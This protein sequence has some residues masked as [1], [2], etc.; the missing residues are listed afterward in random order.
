MCGICGAAQLGRRDDPVEELVDLEAMIDVMSHRGPDDRGS[1]VS[2]QAVLGAR[3]LSIIDVEHGHQP[4]ANEAGDVWA[5]LNGEL[6]NHDAVREELR[7]KGH[8]FRSRCDTEVL[9]HLYEERGADLAKAI[10]GDFGIAVWDDRRGRLVL[11]RDR[12]GVKPLYV[13]RSGDLLVFGSELKAVLASGAIDTALDYD[14]VEAY[15]T[16]GYLP[17]PRTLL[18]DVRKLLPGERL[19]LEDG[20][21]DVARYWS[22]P[23][24]DT[25]SPPR[26]SVDA[27]ADGLVER[28]EE[29]IADRLMSD[30]PLGVM[31]SGG[32]DSSL[33]VAL[34]RRVTSGTIRTFSVGLDDEGA[35]N[36]LAD[37]RLV[38]ETFGTEHHELRASVDDR[39]VPLEDVVWFLD[40]PFAD[41][42]TLG[43]FTL[44]RLTRRHV[45]VALSGQGADEL[46]G[47][48][49]KHE[50]AYLLD[51]YSR[52]PRALRA[53]GRA[54]LRRAPASAGRARDTFLAP[55]AARRLL[56]MSRQLSDAERSELLRGPL[57]SPS[58]AALAAVAPYARPGPALAATL[59]M[60]AQLALPHALL[61]Y[62]D[63]MSMA[64][65]LEVRV[66]YLDERVVE[67]CA[68]LP[69][70]AKVRGVERKRVLRHAAA[71]VLPRPILEKRKV[72]FFRHSTGLWLRAHQTREVQSYLFEG[73]LLSGDFLDRAAV[74]RLATASERSHAADRL[75]LSILMLEIWLSSYLPRAT[76]TRAMARPY[77]PRS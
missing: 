27:A 2:A 30:V 77:T 7:R 70:S 44:S 68:A 24:P 1:F 60:D 17:G 42:S 37:A 57:A 65:S 43:F 63:R 56:A 34:M 10:T 38:A 74:R 55:D 49:P 62:F 47:G 59:F 35:Q 72:G 73:E 50:A 19:V 3:R 11:A 40:E 75:L 36:E 53:A 29:A 12:L 25:P 8:A 4:F 15:L 54:A 20:S 14:A 22:Y 52:L 66:P 6:Y 64:H 48:Y 69:P 39:D 16:L 23:E 46:L 31:L 45:T 26:L 76:A 32:V 58:G 33:L 41:V 5:V 71:R 13:G 9:P 67:Y 18:A 21:V 51:L 28:L 61:H